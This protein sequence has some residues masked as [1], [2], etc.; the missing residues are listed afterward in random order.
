MLLHFLKIDA[1]ASARLRG[2]ARSTLCCRVQLG[3]NAPC[4]VEEGKESWAAVEIARAK[5]ALHP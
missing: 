3:K 5:D 1:E 2:E 4:L